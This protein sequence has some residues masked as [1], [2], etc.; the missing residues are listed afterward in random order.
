MGLGLMAGST[1]HT[2]AELLVYNLLIGLGFTLAFD[3]APQTAVVNWFRRRRATAMGLMMTGFGAG[4][5]LV[6]AMAQAVTAFG[7]RRAVLSG[8]ILVLVI[9]S[10]AAQLLRRSPERYGLLPDGD[11]PGAAD[12]RNCETTGAAELTLRQTLLAP[13]FWLLAVYQA[14][15]MFGVTAVSVH[16]VPYAVDSLDISLT[17][18]GGL[19]TV[20]TACMVTG[21]MLGGF[22][23]DRVNKRLFMLLLTAA[24][25]LVLTLVIFGSSSSVVVM[26]VA[27]QG[28]IVGA[29][30]PLNFSLRAEYFGRK[31]Y[32]TIWGISLALVNVGN[33]GGIVVTG[34]LADRF[35]G[36]REAFIVIFALTC[37]SAVLLGLAKPPRPAGSGAA[38]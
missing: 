27:L 26:F 11:G 8:G 30:S 3:V 37:L 5:A 31:A 7:W 1:I 22:L 23:G 4:G 15:F 12:G 16:L 18:A 25:A 38:G 36:Y 2:V 28:L 20:L 19:V 9:G 17:T 13:S 33:M 34:F 14:M 10:A 24:Q 21:Y 35:G 32:G 29:R 6:P